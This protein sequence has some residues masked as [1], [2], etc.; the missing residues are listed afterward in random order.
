MSVLTI[1]VKG[2]FKYYIMLWEWECSVQAILAFEDVRLS[3][4]SVMMG[5]GGRGG[6]NF[7]TKRVT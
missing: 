7:Q 1:Y 4:I 3:I 6:A 2:L 5:G